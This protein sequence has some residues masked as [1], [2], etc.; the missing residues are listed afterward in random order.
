MWRHAEP[1]SLDLARR[2]LTALEAGDAAAV[3]ELVHP[4]HRD[5]DAEGS[6]G[7]EGARASIRRA[8]ESFADIEILPEDF[9]AAGDRVVARVRFSGTQVGELLG[10]PPTGRRLTAQQ[11]HIWRVAS[12]LLVEHWVVRDEGAVLRQLRCPP[13]PVGSWGNTGV[14]SSVGRSQKIPHG[15]R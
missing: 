11:I 9:V 14:Q 12:G 4:S 2:F 1:A 7:R 15:S 5:H 6:R 13:E 10:H 8:H 3:D